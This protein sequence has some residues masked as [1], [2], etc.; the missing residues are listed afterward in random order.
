MIATRPPGKLSVM[1]LATEVFPEP[2]PPAMPMT[3]GRAV[4]L[5]VPRGC[6]ARQAEHLVHDGQR[7]LLIG[8]FGY[9]P[10]DRL[11]A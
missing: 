2:V 9:R 6:T 10:Q 1:A 11:R 3:T 8:A 7:L 4:K 5:W